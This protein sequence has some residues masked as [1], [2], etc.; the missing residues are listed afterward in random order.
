MVP[1][2]AAGIEGEYIQ[3]AGDDHEAWASKSGLTPEVF[4]NNREALMNAESENDLLDMIQSLPQQQRA[5][6]GEDSRNAMAQTYA[7]IHP[8]TSVF[9]GPASP[10]PHNRQA[11]DLTIDLS[12]QQKTLNPSSPSFSPSTEK[13]SGK[14]ISCPLPAGKKLFSALRIA[15]P[16]IF[17]SLSPPLTSGEKQILI[18]T[19]DGGNDASALCVALAVLSLYY[20]DAGKFVPTGT[21]GMGVQVDKK[22]VRKRLAWIVSACPNVQVPRGALNSVNAFL[23][24][25]P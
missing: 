17:A 10:H 6:G 19:N 21:V 8:T 4:W 18:T 9:V 25:R 15:L 1:Q 5:I 22:C 23:M 24:K 2:G 14:Y 12:Q 20:D 11:F 16:Q 3:G 13:V 7:L